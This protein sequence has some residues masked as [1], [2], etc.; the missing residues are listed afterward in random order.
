MTF[1]TSH[2]YIAAMNSVPL[3]GGPLDG[4]EAPLDDFRD[5]HYCAEID[6]RWVIYDFDG[7]Y[8]PTLTAATDTN[9]SDRLARRDE[10]FGRYS[11]REFH[12]ATGSGMV[13]AQFGRSQ[14]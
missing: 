11:H 1:F 2:D 14:H 5:G 3:I 4:A 9:L 7:N 8:L 6:Q 12:A 10:Q 13:E